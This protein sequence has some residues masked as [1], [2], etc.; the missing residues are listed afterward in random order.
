MKQKIIDAIDFYI[1]WHVPESKQNWPL[2][3]LLLY[4]QNNCKRNN[5][6][7]SAY[8]VPPIVN[9]NVYDEN[10]VG[11]KSLHKH[12]NFTNFITLV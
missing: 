2:K 12:I 5:F 8:Y 6:N 1:I 7:L 11:S 3:A 4:A 10:D 9:L